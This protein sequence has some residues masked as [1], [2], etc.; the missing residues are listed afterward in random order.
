MIHLILFW[1]LDTQW[2]YWV[3][4]RDF[5]EK[6]KVTITLPPSTALLSPYEQ[7]PTT[8]NDRPSSTTPDSERQLQRE[9]RLVTPIC[10]VTVRKRERKRGDGLKKWAGAHTEWKRSRPYKRDGAGLNRKKRQ[11]LSHHTFTMKQVYSSCMLYVSQTNRTTSRLRSETLRVLTSPT[12]RSTILVSGSVRPRRP[13]LSV[14]RSPARIS[15]TLTV[16]K[17]LS[18]LPTQSIGP[19]FSMQSFTN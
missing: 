4:I 18:L 7:Y 1:L 19:F 5:Y 15:A 2:A 8:H 12:R 6:K 9:K 17:Y 14:S 10:F 3:G 11:R 13:W 16:C